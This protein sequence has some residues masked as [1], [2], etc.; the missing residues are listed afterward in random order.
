[1]YHSIFSK[2]EKEEEAYLTIY[3]LNLSISYNVNFVIVIK[4][5]LL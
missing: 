4:L 3:I 5:N 2:N 1:M